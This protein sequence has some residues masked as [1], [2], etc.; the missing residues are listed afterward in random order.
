MLNVVKAKVLMLAIVVALAIFIAIMSM[1]EV[2]EP[3]AKRI[4]SSMGP[5]WLLAVFIVGVIHGLKPDEHTWPITVT[6]GM[7]QS[8]V[9][10]VILAVSTFA[11]ALTLVWTLMSMLIG[12]VV[13]ILR[14]E[15]LDPY[16]DIIVGLTMIGVSAYL[17]FGRHGGQ[18]G[19]ET[20][21]YK[22][23]WVHGLAAAFGGDFFI[24]LILTVA[25]V[26]AISTSLSFLVGLAFGAGSWI[27]Q[28][29]VVLAIYKG[30]IRSVGDWR[31]VA[32]AGRIALGILGLL[33]IGLGLTSMVGMGP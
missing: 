27:A 9:R 19:V 15:V 11:G 5:Y 18:G 22:V 24:V 17:V 10:G 29:F 20:A 21:D 12:Q 31:I 26:P 25:L 16:V 3:L 7:M 28:A 33:M 4:V 30:I 32:D 8:N 2:L 1:P 6:Y 23:I 14:P 13:G